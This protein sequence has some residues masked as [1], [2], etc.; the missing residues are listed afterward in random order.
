MFTLHVCVIILS[1]VSVLLPAMS[2]HNDSQFL[3]PHSILEHGAKNHEIQS[4]YHVVSVSN[5]TKKHGWF[6]F[7]YFLFQRIT[8]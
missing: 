7:I 5:E 2:A 6:E 4:L 1:V 8:N 3:K